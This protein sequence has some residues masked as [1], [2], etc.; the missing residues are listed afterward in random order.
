M[1][2]MLHIFF[3]VKIAIAEGARGFRLRLTVERGHFILVA[4]NAHAPSAA[5]R[6]GF[7]DDWKANL[8]RP[9]TRFV[10][11]S[12][13]PIR[14]RNDRHSMLLHG[15]TSFF[16]FAHQPY[17]VGS[18]TDEFNVTGFADGGKVGVFRKQAI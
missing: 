7:Y 8:P 17:D 14:A 3:Q 15:G 5:A 10:S 4:H 13:D 16:F 12:N 6:R 1:A 18:R 2:R 9:F 11:R